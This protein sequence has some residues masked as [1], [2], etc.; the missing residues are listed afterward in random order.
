MWPIFTLGLIWMIPSTPSANYL[1][2]QLRSQGF[3]TFQ[4]T[5]L[6]IPSA[7]V[8]IITLVAVTLIVERMNQRLLWGAAVGIW[9]L[10]LLIALETLPEKS[11]PWPRWAILTLLVGSPSIH[12][13]MVVLTSR[14]AGSVRTRPVASALYNMSVQISAIAGAN[15]NFF[16]SNLWNYILIVRERST[17][18]RMRTIIDMVIKF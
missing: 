6:V 8:G 12:P 5:L 16:I 7:V 9:V 15:V 2:L 14:N 18:Q 1:T 17:K 13:V 11:M 4:T 3:T 10:I